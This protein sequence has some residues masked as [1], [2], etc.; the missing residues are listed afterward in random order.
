MSVLTRETISGGVSFGAT[1]AIPGAARTLPAA[2]H[3]RGPARHRKLWRGTPTASVRCRRRSIISCRS[4][5]S[6]RYAGA[7]MSSV[8]KSARRPPC[9]LSAITFS[10]IA[11]VSSALSASTEGARVRPD[12]KVAFFD[13]RHGPKGPPKGATGILRMLVEIAEKEKRAA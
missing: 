5:P 13:K 7:A 10:A 1:S 6:D 2:L 4:S 12:M 9:F 8:S 11:S 3:N